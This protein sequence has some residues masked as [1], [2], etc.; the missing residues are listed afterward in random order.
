MVDMCTYHMPENPLR[1]P[2]RNMYNFI[3]TVICVEVNVAVQPSSHSFPTN[4]SAPDWRWGK[5][6]SVLDLLYNNRLR[7]SS[8]LWVARP[9]LPSGRRTCGP[10]IILTL[11]THG[12]STLMYFCV[13]PVS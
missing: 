8:T 4:I 1:V 12:V 13:A 5:M 10:C 9:R 11:F 6:C 7:L 3:S 2:S